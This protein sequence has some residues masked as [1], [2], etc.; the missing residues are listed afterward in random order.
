MSQP[1][2]APYHFVPL[3]KWVY[4]PDWAHLVS[5]DVPFEDG[6]SG[7]IEYTLTNKTP[8]CVGDSKDESG[9]LKIARNPNGTP[10]IPGSSLKGMIR[11]VLEIASFGKFNTVDDRR[12]SFRDVSRDS[13]YLLN[14]IKPNKVIGGW[15]KYDA[16][17]ECWAF[18]QSEFTPVFHDDLNKVAKTNIFNEAF[19]QPA[20]EKY[21][22][23]RLDSLKA[24]SFDLGKQRMEGTRGKT[25]S[26]ECACNLAQ[27]QLSGIPV[28][29]GFRPGSKKYWSTRL[30]FSYLF[31]QAQPKEQAIAVD[32]T[33]VND[34]FTNHNEDLVKELRQHPHPELG[35]P[36]F[37]LHKKGEIACFGFA[38]MPRVTYKNAI[39][40]LIERHNKAH[41][42]DVHFDM[43]ELM[44]GTLREKGLG[45]KSRVSFSD[46]VATD[47]CHGD[48]YQ[49]VPTVLGSPQ[50][51]FL[52]GYIEQDTKKADNTYQSYDDDSARVSGWKRYPARK[53]YTHFSPEKD[54]ENVLSK[55][56][57]LKPE[58][59]FTGQVTFNN[60]KPEELSALIWC[61]TLDNS[62]ERYHSLGHAKPLGAGSVVIALNQ[63]TSF[64]LT[65]SGDVMHNVDAATW[66]DC[67]STHMNER[68][69]PQG[70]W[71][72]SPQIE[73]LMAL[74]DMSVED[75]NDFA[76]MRLEGYQAANNNTL[77]LPNLDI[78]GR[79]L[80]RT[81]DDNRSMGSKAFARGRLNNLFDNSDSFHL[82]EQALSEQYCDN[83]AMQQQKQQ[84][85]Q[86]KAQLKNADISPFERI[87]GLLPLMIESQDVLSSTDKKNKVKELRE[88]IKEVKDIELNDDEKSTLISLFEKIQLSSKD[89]D[90]VIKY[91]KK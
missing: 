73:H 20:E 87:C 64:T 74:T 38:K 9:V 39:V 53:E 36:V 27:G 30:N 52:G 25:V 62:N 66:S 51:T 69:D 80:S 41:T 42:S 18:R 70:Y 77:A 84:M 67:F 78:N 7:K 31:Y 72:K 35:I 60:L 46:A 55:F 89:T 4:M 16:D 86:E 91:L 12:F 57:L 37:A 48:V 11:N 90:K 61:L 15:L 14:V 17:K 65:H 23:Y 75:S 71:S 79:T 32:T 85:A 1:I 63:A 2:H 29:S 3:S 47:D 26:V 45:L 22:E 24:L 43:A 34:L 88:I 21:E 59:T 81:L 6:L 68:Y 82:G 58:K 76:Y 44:L 83:L 33:L 10:I 19:K 5:H 54:N 28:F 50:A 13:H 56:E 49:A 8:L 40:K